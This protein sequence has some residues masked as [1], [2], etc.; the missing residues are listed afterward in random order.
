M[1]RPLRPAVV[2]V[3]LLLGVAHAHFLELLPTEDLVT[4]ASEPVVELE[5]VFTHPLEG[6]PAM[7]MERPVRF[8]VAFDGTTLDLGH[9]LEADALGGVP[10]WRARVPVAGPGDHRF[11]VEPAP[12]FEAAEGKAI[13]HYTKVIVNAY[14]L[15]EGWDEPIGLPVE[16][17]PLV[18]PYDVWTGQ[19]F[20]GIVLQDGAPVPFAEV[21]VEWRNDGTLDA[22]AL[23]FTTQAI[24]ADAGGAFAFALT[25]AGW[26]GFAALVDGDVPIVGPDGEP[27]DVELG[28][29]IWVRARDVD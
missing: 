2:A 27:W 11:F 14:G 23:A 17:L 28:G 19:L 8:G 5:L 26:W 24:R 6:G 13:V 21:E 16:I 12:Y 15:A 29:L 4:P 1:P 20:R 7:P 10:T 22:A 18:R 9:L 25:R 3:V